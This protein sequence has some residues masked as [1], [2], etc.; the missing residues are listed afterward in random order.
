MIPRFCHKF[1]GIYWHPWLPSTLLHF[2]GGRFVAPATSPRFQFQGV[3]GHLQTSCLQPS[4]WKHVI[5]LWSC[6]LP[7]LDFYLDPWYYIDWHYHPFHFLTVE[8]YWLSFSVVS[9][10]PLATT[11]IACST[12]Q[13]PS[14]LPK[15]VSLGHPPL[16]SPLALTHPLGLLSWVENMLSSCHH[17]SS[18]CNWTI[19]CKAHEKDDPLSVVAL[20]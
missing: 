16:V 6:P 11:Q 5:P 2:L 14:P 4:H 13:Y 7:L 15:S 8:G 12:L 10:L 1:A 3:F 9:V 19:P 18:T 20:H 17:T